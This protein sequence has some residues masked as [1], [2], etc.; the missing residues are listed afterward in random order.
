MQQSCSISFYSTLKLLSFSHANSFYRSDKLP[1]S[2]N[3]QLRRNP[4]V[5]GLADSNG[6]QWVALTHHIK[7]NKKFAKQIQN[8]SHRSVSEKLKAVLRLSPK[9]HF[10]ISRFLG[11][12]RHPGFQDLCN[13]LCAT[14]V[15]RELFS[16]GV[17]SNLK[18]SRVFEVYFRHFSMVELLLFES[19][20]SSTLLAI[21]ANFTMVEFS[22]FIISHSHAHGHI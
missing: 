13:N 7:N 2:I 21:S 20:I 9:D 19:D 5:V 3:L 8:E 4:R 18:E 10:S 17:F 16:I 11:L 6:D 1:P 15:G 12:W 22:L 14:G